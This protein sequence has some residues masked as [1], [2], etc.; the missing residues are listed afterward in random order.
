MLAGANFPV[1]ARNFRTVLNNN[2]LLLVVSDFDGNVSS[3]SPV[4]TVD[5]SLRE[6]GIIV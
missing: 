1:L 4:H 5:G 3:V 6:H 2:T